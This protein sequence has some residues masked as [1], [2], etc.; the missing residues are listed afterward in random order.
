MSRYKTQ[1]PVFPSV[2][3]LRLHIF[4]LVGQ[5][6]ACLLLISFRLQKSKEDRLKPVLLNTAK[7]QPAGFQMLALD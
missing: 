3:A 1:S 5:A 2:K 7:L 6:S 4:R